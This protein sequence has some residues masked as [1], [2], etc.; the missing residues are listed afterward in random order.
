MSNH[1]L[2]KST[3]IAA[4]LRETKELDHMPHE[5]HQRDTAVDPRPFQTGS[6]LLTQVKL[7]VW[8]SL[9]V[10]VVSLHVVDMTVGAYSDCEN[11]WL[12]GA[13]H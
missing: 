8:V 3:G 4:A 10:D 12:L 1:I 13:I 7:E 9:E 2:D 6:G 5:A 11:V